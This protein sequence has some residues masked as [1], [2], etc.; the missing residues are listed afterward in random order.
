MFKD[1]A[2]NFIGRFW[3][4]LSNFLF[5]PLYIKFLGFD[6]YSIISF[7][8]VIAGLM[9]M[10]DAGLTAT[11]SREFARLD[12]TVNEK[13]N[14]FKTLETSY[15]IIC[16]LCTLS[17]LMFTSNIARSWLNLNTIEV[18]KV[19]F[20]LKIVIVDFG[21][22]LI[23]RF[24]LGGLL[25]LQKQ[26][27]ANIYQV[28]WGVV[29]NGLVLIVILILPSLKL[30]FIWQAVSTVFFTV[31]IRFALIRSLTGYYKYYY[32]PTIDILVFKK[33]WRFTGGMLLISL[34]ACLNTQMD[35]IVISK[36]LPIKSLGYYTLGITLSMGIITIINP[37]S[38][39]LLPRFTALYSEKKNFEAANLYSKISLF[40]SILIFSIMSN[41]M[42][43]SRELLWIWTGDKELSQMTSVYLPIIAFAMGMLSLQIMAFNVCVAN[44]YT[45]LN[46]LLGLLSLF[47]TIPGYWFATRYF[48]A[49]GTAYVFCFVQ[50]LT[51][52]F[53]VY[54]VNK[55]FSIAQ[56]LLSLYFKQML[57]PLILSL[58][59]AFLFSFIS[60]EI[61]NS[62]IITLL[63]IGLSTFFAAVIS[64]LVLVDKNQIKYIYSLILNFKK[65]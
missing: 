14:L 22:Q 20:F 58:L 36:L 45:K 59:V 3:S 55:K 40:V 23:M 5:I 1:I 24:Y 63:L 48:G 8:L 34:V 56:S 28:I 30:F 26:I 19:S 2:A 32:R 52:F 31:L 13:I 6:S 65:K 27:T 18:E 41:M 51:T 12:V 11:L 47:V 10:L 46:N 53:Y 38:T 61:P 25:G 54:Y 35:K 7:S 62:R 43:F 17:V 16:G 29:R 64:V 4:I 33:V 9:A 37:I 60:S 21:F 42:V 15:F 44:G 39:A 57:F 49:I 50:S